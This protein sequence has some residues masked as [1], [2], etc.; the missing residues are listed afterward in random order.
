MVKVNETTKPPVSVENVNNDDLF[1][2]LDSSTLV[3]GFPTVRTIRY[4]ELIKLQNIVTSWSATPSDEN[5]PSEKLVY[6]AI[7]GI[8]QLVGDHDASEGEIPS[9]SFNKGDYWRIS[10]AGTIPGM[11]PVDQLEIGDIIVAKQDNPTQGSH[12]FTLQAN[13]QLLEDN[14]SN[15]LIE[16]PEDTATPP[17]T[18]ELYENGNKIVRIRK[19]A[20]D[21]LNSVT[22][23]WATPW[24]MDTTK[25]IQYRV[26]GIITEAIGP[27][28]ENIQFKL[29]GYGVENGNDSND[30]FGTAVVLTKG[31]ETDNAQNDVFVTP[32]SDNV[33]IPGIERDSINQ[34]LFERLGGTDTYNQKI[35][36]IEVEIKYIKR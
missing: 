29:S 35:G 2:I 15:I 4:S 32:W 10:T 8:G 1:I 30:S 34:I 11:T 24:D 21:S 31:F 22:F 18:S 6:D 5:I 17:E 23:D 20:G 19:F 27:D 7:A 26:K 33:T 12:F 14:V 36:I 16:F 25:Q 3:G 28:T 13:L 9:G